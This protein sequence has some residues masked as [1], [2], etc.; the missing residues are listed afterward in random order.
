MP[1]LR[2]VDE[3][4]LWEVQAAVLMI[5]LLFTF[6]RSETPCPKSHTG[7]EAFFRTKHLQVCDVEVRA[8]Q[9]VPCL[10]VR[11]K[12]IKQ[13]P[14]VERAEA[15]GNEDWVLVGD[16]QSEPVFSVLRWVRILFGLHGGPRAREG[17]FFVSRDGT[18]ALLYG[19]AMEQCRALWARVVGVE[20]AHTYGLH[21]LRVAG[22]D[23]SRRTA[24]GEELA[25]AHGGWHNTAHTRYARFSM[26]EVLAIPAHIASHA[27]AED[28]GF[29]PMLARAAPLPASAPAVA[30]ARERECVCRRA[31]F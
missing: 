24:V 28:S 31:R 12:A 2:T 4:V 7:A 8:V 16:V 10:A 6:C 5:V 19:A 14:R 11:L 18:R 30:G 25:V 21:S 1:S 9:G 27:D 29:A 20:E 17:P 23:A 22:Y 3:R 13:D 26:A 15:A